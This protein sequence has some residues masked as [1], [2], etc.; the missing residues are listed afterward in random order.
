M[1]DAELLS[2]MRSDW[3][4]RARE[5]ANYYVAF[6]R[7]QQDDDEFL[8]T[9][10][11]VVRALKAE[12]RRLP[13]ETPVRARRALE[14]G[15]GPGRLMLPL[16]KCFGEIHGIDVS[17]EMV[18]KARDRLRHI[19]HLHVHC[20]SGADL[21]GF[22]DESFDF[23]Y[24]YAVFQHIPSEEVVFQYLGEVRRV[25][26]AG[27]I[28]HCQ[29]N[30]LPK[31]AKHYDT[32]SGARI[33]AQQVSR[34]ARKHDFQ[35]L[36]L[37]GALTQYMWTTWRKRPAGWALALG[38]QA[39]PKMSKIRAI[40]NCHT[41]EPMAP[42]S[43]RFASISLWLEDLPSDFDL[44]HVEV[45]VDGL[46]ATPTYIGPPQPDGLCQFNV[47]LPP[48]CRTGILR[49]EAAWL[50]KALCTPGCVR[51]IPAPPDVPRV[52]S[53]TDGVDLLAG[54]RI[55]SRSVKL[56]IEEVTSPEQLTVAVDGVPV[57]DLDVFCTN[58]FNLRHEMNFTLPEAI[59]PGPHSLEP[60]FGRSNST[61]IPIE[62]V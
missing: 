28:L 7:K 2:R 27:G 61:P 36:A 60:E 17:D 49:V 31:T 11:D 52:L 12:L 55:V 43:G 16:S 51:I 62:V 32:W 41:G 42:A 23:V 21:A 14:I 3:N 37:E 18:A 20:S 59:G 53:V 29:I 46:A 9:A 54:R 45:R 30:G 10:A 19:P 39:P 4:E 56:V 47:I 5:D 24:S 44:N 48:E 22:A 33:G 34:F 13:G 26:K 1:A 38:Q 40:G 15:C 58:P 25:L 35:L 8:S 6:G 57:R 50:G